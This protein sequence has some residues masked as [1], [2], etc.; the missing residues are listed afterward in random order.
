MADEKPTSKLD[1]T[2]APLW[3]LGIAVVVTSL[4]GAMTS[5][6]VAMRPEIQNYLV[7]R[8]NI[9][10]KQMENS[11]AEYNSLLK[12]ITSNQEQITDLGKQLGLAQLE[13]DRLF[14]RVRLLETEVAKMV[15]ELNACKQQLA[16]KGR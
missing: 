11:R 2:K 5:L 9:E 12:L 10:I 14:E 8:E 4:I 13:K 3:S 6:Y 15:G 16:A 1:L 7:S